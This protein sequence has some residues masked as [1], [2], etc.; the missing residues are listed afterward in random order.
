V[1]RRAQNQEGRDCLV[2][3]RIDGRIILRMDFKEIWYG[4][5]DWIKIGSSG[6]ALVNTVTAQKYRPD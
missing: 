5:F 2:D 4:D 6:G 1:T 3:I